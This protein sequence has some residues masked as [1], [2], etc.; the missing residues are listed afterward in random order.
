LSCLGWFRRKN[1]RP[2]K[3]AVTDWRAIIVTTAHA[4]SRRLCGLT[5]SDTGYPSAF[6]ELAY[7]A[8]LAADMSSDGNTEAIISA[9]EN[10]FFAYED[11][12]SLWQS[13]ELVW[14][15]EICEHA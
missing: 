11:G 1:I 5:G 9:V 2:A 10:E 15:R 12:A 8:A 4:R 6:I 7:A 14:H 13:D 3:R